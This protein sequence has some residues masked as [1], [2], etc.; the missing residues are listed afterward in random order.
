MSIYCPPRKALVHF[1]ARS[2]CRKHTESL[3]I[4]AQRATKGT[5]NDEPFFPPFRRIIHL[6]LY[7]VNQKTLR[8]GHNSLCVPDGGYGNPPYIFL[9]RRVCSHT[10]RSRASPIMAES[11]DEQ[12]F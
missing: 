4:A 1:I 10:D 6:L 9:N 12:T 11:Q 8:F 3:S 5:I 7:S 2:K